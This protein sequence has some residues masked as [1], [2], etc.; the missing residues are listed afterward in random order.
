MDKKNNCRH[1]R[2]ET[3]NIAKLENKSFWKGGDPSTRQYWCL[4]TMNTIGPDSRMVG[5]ED[6]VNKRS[7]FEEK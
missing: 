1:L 4:V 3:E 5:E 2:S 6:C 7:C